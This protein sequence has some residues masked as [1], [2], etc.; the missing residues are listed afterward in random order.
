ML[1]LIGV[2][3]VLIFVGIII[4]RAAPALGVPPTV[5][6][7]LLLLLALVFV[8]HVLGVLGLLPAAWTFR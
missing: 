6:Q 8:I 2:L 7:L 1:T 4:Q 5:T 3:I